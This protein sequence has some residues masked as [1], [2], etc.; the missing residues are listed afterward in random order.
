MLL[1]MQSV[2]LVFGKKQLEFE[3]CHEPYRAVCMKNGGVLQPRFFNA[4]PAPGLLVCDGNGWSWQT[5]LY[6]PCP[7]HVGGLSVS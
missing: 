7:P 1:K 3:W 2:I 4:E 5:G 6:T